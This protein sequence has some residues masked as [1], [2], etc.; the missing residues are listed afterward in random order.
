MGPNKEQVEPGHNR[1]GDPEDEKSPGKSSILNNPV[2]KRSEWPLLDM[3]RENGSYVI[4]INLPG[5]DK[6]HINVIASGDT[7]SIWGWGEGPEGNTDGSNHEHRKDL[8]SERF[9]GSFRR[10]VSLPEDADLDNLKIDYENG[11]LTVVVPGSEIS[12]K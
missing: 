3:Y 8:Y 9:T 12:R 6:E 1:H 4:K 2:D 11:V 10:D 7:V 5:R